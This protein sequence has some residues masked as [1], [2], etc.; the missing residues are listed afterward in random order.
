M[1]ASRGMNGTSHIDGDAAAPRRGGWLLLL[2][3]WVALPLAADDADPLAGAFEVSSASVVNRRGVWELTAHVRYP[4]SERIRSALQDGVTLTF[5][6][7]VAITRHRRFWLDAD[8]LSLDLRR[9]LSYHVVSDR[10]V[11]TS[12]DGREIETF[13]TI[14]A[15]LAR[16][17]DVADWPVIV[18]S[19]LSG[20]GP[21][22]VSV[23]AGVR[24]GRMPDALRALV[25][26]SDA[27]HRTSEW[28]RW[29]LPR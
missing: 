22:Q 28:Y 26:W 10:Y 9:D 24:R 13:P 25:F 20:E 18:D 16:L 6:L 12:A 5:D 21:W 19:Q 1:L 11:L 17:G 29:T 23:R 3:L 4:L 14:E 27:W 7:E 15:A 2:A 8:V